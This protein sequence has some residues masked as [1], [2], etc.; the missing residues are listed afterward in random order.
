MGGGPPPAEIQGLRGGHW[1]PLVQPL[2]APSCAT[3][4]APWPQRYGVV[5]GDGHGCAGGGASDAVGA[6]GG[7]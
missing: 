6:D 7:G 2:R 5:Q 1:A 3:P 4:P